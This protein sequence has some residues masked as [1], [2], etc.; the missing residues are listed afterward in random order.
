MAVETAGNG[1]GLN[2]SG[3]SVQ[4]PPDDARPTNSDPVRPTPKAR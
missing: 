2:Y 1:G 4:T 3:R